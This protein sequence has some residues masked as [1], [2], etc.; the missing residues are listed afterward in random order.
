MLFVLG[1][2]A[3]LA[4]VFGP[5]L[6]AQAVLR[7]YRDE[8]PDFPGTGGELARHLLDQAGLH[9]VPVEVTDKGDHYDPEAKAVRLT[10]IHHRGRSLVA[11][12]V[13]AHEVGHALQDKDGYAPLA[14]RVRLARMAVGVEMVGSA[15]VYAAFALAA[16]ARAPSLAAA[17]VG[18]GATSRFAMVA[19]HAITLPV[20]WNASFA[21]AL[22][23]LDAGNYV[24]KED[25][26]PAKR[27]L[28]ACALT[29]V[30]GSLV[31]LLN[32]W[33]WLRFMR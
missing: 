6:Y 11:V 17:A 4:L 29:Y 18:I 23:L 30:A 8:R 5:S 3:V 25:L 20:E 33:R 26:G 21:R 9:H 13:A 10:P 16:I 19:V 22:P 14:L 27:I 12:V 31:S 24:A 32:L 28:R 1:G 7:W 2:L 15:L